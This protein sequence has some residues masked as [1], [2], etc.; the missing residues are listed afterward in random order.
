[1]MQTE[2]G[3]K[4]EGASLLSLIQPQCPSGMPTKHQPADHTEMWFAESPPR[5][6]KAQYKR[7][8]LQQKENGLMTLG[9]LHSLSKLQFPYLYKGGNTSFQGYHKD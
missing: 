5:H 9:K 7:A 3:G 6:H 2:T 8:G 1:M 4:Q